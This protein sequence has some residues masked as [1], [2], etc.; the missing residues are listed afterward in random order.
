MHIPKSTSQNHRRYSVWCILEI[1]EK[2]LL[3]AL[4]ESWEKGNQQKNEIRKS[5][6]CLQE[7]DSCVCVCA[8]VRARASVSQQYHSGISKIACIQF[9]ASVKLQGLSSCIGGGVLVCVH[10]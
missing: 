6:Q 2:W 8:C 3:I 10:N 4:Q 1:S 5:V 9:L 7:L